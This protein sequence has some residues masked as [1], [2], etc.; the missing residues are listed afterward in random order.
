VVPENKVIPPLLIEIVEKPED[1]G[2]YA[3][4]L[5]KLFVF[6]QLVAVPQVKISVPVVIIILYCRIIEIPV[7]GKIVY[8]AS[9]APVTVAHQN[10][11]RGVIE[12]NLGSGFEYFCHTV[13]CGF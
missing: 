12:K 10:Q 3:A 1:I 7:L 9:V 8:P 6:P 13:E 5:A 2:I 11:S 4:D